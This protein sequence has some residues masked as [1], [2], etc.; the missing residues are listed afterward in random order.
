MGEGRMGEVYEADR[1]DPS[2]KKR[3]AVK[4]IAGRSSATCWPSA[5][6]A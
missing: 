1:L 5:F 2:F 3:I 4:V 6:S